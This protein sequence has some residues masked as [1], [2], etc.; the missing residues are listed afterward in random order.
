M[1]K[2]YLFQMTDEEN[3]SFRADAK[4]R[5]LSFADWLRVCLTEQAGRQPV[6]FALPV[7]EQPAPKPEPAPVTPARIPVAHVG[8]G[9]IEGVSSFTQAREA[10]RDLAQRSGKCTA[11]VARGT[12]C[13]LCGE[14]HK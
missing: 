2:S 1:T 4:R 7:K 10:A 5:G 12:R 9:R 8:G 3:E 13:K 14:V 11:D 6:V